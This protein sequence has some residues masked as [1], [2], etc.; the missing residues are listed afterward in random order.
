[1][2]SYVPGI[3]DAAKNMSD[4]INP[5]GSSACKAT[6]NGKKGF[7]NH[8]GVKGKHGRDTNQSGGNWLGKAF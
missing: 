1:M 5:S 3:G 8:D 2:A 6:P 4:S 7:Q